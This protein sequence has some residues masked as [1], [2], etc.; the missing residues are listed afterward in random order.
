VTA[1]QTLFFQDIKVIIDDGG[2]TDTATSKNVP[3]GGG[4]AVFSAKFIQEIDD[5][6]LPGGQFIQLSPR[7][8]VLTERLFCQNN[9]IKS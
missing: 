3:D 4:V 5:L 8:V 1:D 2:G 7:Y 6:L 9:T